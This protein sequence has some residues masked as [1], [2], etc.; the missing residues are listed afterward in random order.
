VS[1]ANRLINTALQRGVGLARTKK[2]FKRFPRR[3]R[4][5]H[6]AKAAVL[7]RADSGKKVRLRAQSPEKVLRLLLRD[8]AAPAQ[9]FRF[10][11]GG[12]GFFDVPG[13]VVE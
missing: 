1:D 8:F 13:A 12:F 2:P 4:A 6:R 7:L 5:E 3:L 10:R 11:A 9:N